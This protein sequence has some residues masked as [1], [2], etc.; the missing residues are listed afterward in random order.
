MITSLLEF[1]LLLNVC[2]SDHGRAFPRHDPVVVVVVVVAYED[3]DD[4]DEG[5]NDSLKLIVCLSNQSP[6][7]AKV[8]IPIQPI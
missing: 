1:S 8:I 6:T 3:E 2:P 5:G 4:E 7:F